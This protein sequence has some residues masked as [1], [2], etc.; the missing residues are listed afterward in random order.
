MSEDRMKPIARLSD[1]LRQSDWLWVD[2]ARPPHTG[3]R[4]DYRAPV[5]I[6]A[7]IAGSGADTPTTRAM[8]AMRCT[9]CKWKG[10]TFT[11]PSWGGLDKGWQQFPEGWTNE[12]REER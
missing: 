10:A 12:A 5:K 6:D 4:C 2:C 1:L 7:L 8:A 9:K 3:S 11:M